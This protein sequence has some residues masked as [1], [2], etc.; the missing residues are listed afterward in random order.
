MRIYRLHIRPKGGLG[1][2]S[3]SFKY[4]LQQHVLGVGWGV[5]GSPSTWTSYEKSA[6]KKYGQHRLNGVRYLHDNVKPKDLIW[7]RDTKGN[8]Y[9]A[10]VRAS[11]GKTSSDQAWAYL[12]TPDGR[13]A[14][15]LNVVRCRILPV[16]QADDVPGKVIA[17]FR[18]RRVIQS[19]A[20][21]TTVMY[22]QFL[23][24]EL[25][26]SEEYR[27]PRLER[28]DLFSFL[29]DK[30]AE[31]LVFIYLQYKGWVVVPNSR[32][33]DTWRYEFIAIH[34]KTGERAVV[35]VKSGHTPLAT[36]YL[37]GRNERVFLFQTH[38][39]YVGASKPNV[40]RI[41][42]KAIEE[43]IRSHIEIMPAV[44]RRWVVFVDRMNSSH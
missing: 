16:R 39:H 2:T 26:G 32:E 7:T 3:F 1:D 33:A 9:L 8:Y 14:D 31:D 42:R 28:C 12:D 4:C 5:S 36:D 44:V 6:L 18:P 22:S 25:A 38:E 23:W 13:D 41:T 17:C 20:D 10:R 21:E 34:K 19:I 43:F 40:V 29:D 24:N 35:Q 37:S 27:L 11:K 15:I 30:T